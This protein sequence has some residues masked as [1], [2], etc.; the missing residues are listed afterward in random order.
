MYTLM[1][2]AQFFGVSEFG[3]LILAKLRGHGFLPIFLTSLAVTETFLILS[4]LSLHG[5]GM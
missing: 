3:S 4:N 2:I 1:S 5:S